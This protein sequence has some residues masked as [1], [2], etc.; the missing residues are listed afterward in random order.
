MTDITIILG[1]YSV[2]GIGPDI[3]T[4]PELKTM[5]YLCA[6]DLFSMTVVPTSVP[7]PVCLK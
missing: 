6:E 3:S 5:K 4:V 7:G 2:L 1:L